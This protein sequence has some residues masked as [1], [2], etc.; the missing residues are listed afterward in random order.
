MSRR[1]NDQLPAPPE[2]KARV[3]AKLVEL[4]LSQ[5]QLAAQL[6][7]SQSG[8]S[9]ALS[10]KQA[11]ATYVIEISEALGIEV[12]L[13]VRAILAARRLS[14]RSDAVLMRAV[15]LMEAAADA[16]DA[17]AGVTPERRPGK[18]RLRAVPDDTAE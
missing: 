5:H 4:G 2:W 13:Q 12:P 14:G 3:R 17:V 11:T 1:Y 10:P 7:I 15:Q 9:H 18:P 6:K 8:I 16:E